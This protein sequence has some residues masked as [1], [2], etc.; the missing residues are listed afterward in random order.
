[1]ISQ[2][3]Q[4]RMRTIYERPRHTNRRYGGAASGALRRLASG[5]CGQIEALY[6]R[7]GADMQR[8]CA[9]GS[10]LSQSLVRRAPRFACHGP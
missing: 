6:G 2:F 7:F 1:M 9:R 10:H 4:Y 5:A 3:I 8:N